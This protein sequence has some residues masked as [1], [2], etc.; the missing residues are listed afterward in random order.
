VERSRIDWRHRQTHSADR[1]RRLCSPR[2]RQLEHPGRQRQSQYNTHEIW[3]DKDGK[4]LHPHTNYYVGGNTKFYGAPFS[5]AR[6]K[7]F[8]ELTHG[9]GISPAWPVK[10][11]EMEPYYLQ[12]E[13]LYHVHGQRGEDPT[14]PAASGPYPHPWSATSRESSNCT[15][16]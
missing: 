3:H 2:S 9:G 16:I 13:N 4:E 11:A 6:R 14:E 15:T 5:P 10:Y 7:I 1:A 12:A 8:G